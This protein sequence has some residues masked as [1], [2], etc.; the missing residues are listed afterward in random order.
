MNK[1]VR[2]T[3]KG[4]GVQWI[5]MYVNLFLDLQIRHVYILALYSM[6]IEYRYYRCLVINKYYRNDS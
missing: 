4:N 3:L 2:I 6:I 5:F 1:M